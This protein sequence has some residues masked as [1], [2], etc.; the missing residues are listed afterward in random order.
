VDLDQA[1]E[2]EQPRLLVEQR[3]VLVLQR[4]DDQQHGVGTVHRRLVELVDVD[5]E[6]LLQ[7][8]Q[9]RRRPRRPQVVER[10]AEV[11]PVGEHRERGGTAA[12]ERG[13]DL[14]DGRPGGDLSRARGTALELGDQREA[15]S[16]QRLAERAR[17]AEGPD[18]VA[19]VLDRDDPLAALDV[20][21]RCPHELLELAHV[22]SRVD[23]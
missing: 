12:L 8:R 14:R 5:D 21:P 16:D 4:R 1:V 17:S 2:V 22:R 20:G 3:Q 18:R 7:D 13:T 19:Q 11:G 10:A 15:G 9:A 23:D 6:V